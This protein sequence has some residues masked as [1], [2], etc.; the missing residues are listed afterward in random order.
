MNKIS[1]HRPTCLVGLVALALAAGCRARHGEPGG[2]LPP[3]YVFDRINDEGIARAVEGLRSWGEEQ[4]G[5]D[6][7]ALYQ[8]VEILPPTP[9]VQPYGVGVYQQEERL[10]V[11]LTT[12][13]GWSNLSAAE[14]EARVADAFREAARR[15][16]ELDREPPL[17]PTLTVQTPQG[18]ELA[19]VNRLDPDKKNVHGDD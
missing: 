9:T 13:P 19:W 7:Q 11:I 2:D 1:T 10:P 12:G 16:G 3:A 4:A 15:L 5:G 18:F 17:L 6:R 14:K 8:K